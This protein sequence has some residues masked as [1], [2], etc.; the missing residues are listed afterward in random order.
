MNSKNKI[1]EDAAETI[2]KMV[3]DTVVLHIEMA[4]LV[5]ETYGSPR[6]YQKANHVE[7]ELW[8]GYGMF[9]ETVQKV[10]Y[11]VSPPTE[12]AGL[13]EGQA[14][15]GVKQIKVATT[16]M[17]RINMDEIPENKRADTLT[18]TNKWANINIMLGAGTKHKQV[19]TKE[20]IVD[21]TG[22]D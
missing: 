22:T 3:Y 19:E 10:G 17:T 6:Y 14:K 5:F 2:S 1:I 13:C 18:I 11:K 4:E 9:L 8:K 21:R 15:R 20:R 7:E 12:Q 16:K